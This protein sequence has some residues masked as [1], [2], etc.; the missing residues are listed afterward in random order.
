MDITNVKTSERTKRVFFLLVNCAFM[1]LTKLLIFIL[2]A[3][4][5]FDY[6]ANISNV[7]LTIMRYPFLDDCHNAKA[8]KCKDVLTVLLGYTVLFQNYLK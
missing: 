5:F 3:N 7:I 8:E 2:V 6:V 1:L 4:T